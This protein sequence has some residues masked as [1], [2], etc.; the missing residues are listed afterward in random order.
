MTIL[1]GIMSFIFSIFGIFLGSTMGI[2]IG[3]GI[4]HLILIAFG[5]QAKFENTIKFS[6]AGGVSH[7]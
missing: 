7:L 6:L 2:V 1:L 4:I 3:H 5:G